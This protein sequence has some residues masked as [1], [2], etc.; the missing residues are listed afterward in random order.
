M[1]SSLGPPQQRS[2][3]HTTPIQ[4]REHARPRSQHCVQ[5]SKPGTRHCTEHQKALP[6][7]P[8]PWFIDKKTNNNPSQ[9]TKT[10]TKKLATERERASKNTFGLSVQLAMPTQQLTDAGVRISRIATC[11]ITSHARHCPFCCDRPKGF[12]NHQILTPNRYVVSIPH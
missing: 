10:K 7:S 6:P 1:F 11:T 12:P 5:R 4:D 3:K 9:N 2:P 8:Q